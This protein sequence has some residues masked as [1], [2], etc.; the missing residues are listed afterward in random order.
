M[1]SSWK[2]SNDHFR[3]NAFLCCSTG[4]HTTVNFHINRSNQAI[5]III[6][7]RE[8]LTLLSNSSVLK[9]CWFYPVAFQTCTS[10]FRHS[11][12]AKGWI[13]LL[14]RSI[15]YSPDTSAYRLLLVTCNCVVCRWLWLILQCDSPTTFE[16][17][18]RWGL[19]L[20]VVSGAIFLLLSV[21]SPKF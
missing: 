12:K 14:N 4:S 2:C 10:N 11:M 17:P 6:N 18:D 3:A 16:S 9:A 15:L 5:W 8:G 19:L 1:S 21:K 20:S 7:D 13:K